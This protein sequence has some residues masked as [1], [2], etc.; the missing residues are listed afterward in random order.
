M[1]KLTAKQLLDSF[2]AFA[3]LAQQKLPAG[4][5]RLAYQLG[6]SWKQLNSE[7]EQ[8]K[9]QEEEI[10]RAFGAEAKNN[11]LQIDFDKLSDAEREDFNQQV[12]DLQAI[13]LEIWGH[14][15]TLADLEKMAVNLSAAEFNLLSWL[16]E[17]EAEI[18]PEAPAENA[19]AATA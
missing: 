13:P 7:L 10:Y 14:K 17:E 8:I 12:L 6:K 2:Q 18:A 9:K 4:C 15:L 5:Q 19:Q 1:L 3:F 11:L 16:I